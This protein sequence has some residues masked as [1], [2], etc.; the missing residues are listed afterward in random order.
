MNAAPLAF[1]DDQ[2]VRCPLLLGEPGDD[3][4]G[5]DALEHLPALSR[6]SETVDS[7]RAGNYLEGLIWAES[8]LI[9]APLNG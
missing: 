8:C 3:P 7:F 2:S 4:L 6:H 9:I 5:G 1:S